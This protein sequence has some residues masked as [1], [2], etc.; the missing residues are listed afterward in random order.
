[1]NIKLL[2]AKRITKAPLVIEDSCDVLNL[3]RVHAE[4]AIVINNT[5]KLSE[6][7]LEKTTARIC[8]RRPINILMDKESKLNST[9]QLI[10][11]MANLGRVNLDVLYVL[12][13]VSVVSGRINKLY[14]NT[15]SAINLGDTDVRF[16]YA[17]GESMPKLIRTGSMKP[18]PDVIK[19]TDEKLKHTLEI[20]SR[21]RTY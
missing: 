13:G 5:G 6:L 9:A 21:E 8:S 10:V 15:S 3:Y 2:K 16:I 12:R 4:K 14:L 1:M 7:S 19:V 11:N 17:I 20:F 18:I